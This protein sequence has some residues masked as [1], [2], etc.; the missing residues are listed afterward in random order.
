MIAKGMD[1]VNAVTNYLNEG[2]IPVIVYDQPFYALDKKPQ[3]TGSAQYGENKLVVMMGAFHSGI[4]PWKSLGKLLEDSGWR[5]V[6][7]E[8]D[9][10]SVRRAGAIA[11]VNHVLRTRQPFLFDTCNK[12]HI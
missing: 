12:K 1:V 11:D 4:S 3:W 10:T 5:S 9:V 8:A 2:Q 7:S 6:L